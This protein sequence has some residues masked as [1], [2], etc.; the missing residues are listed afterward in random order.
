[1]STGDVLK[2]LFADE[3]VNIGCDTTE[4]LPIIKFSTDSYPRS[5]FNCHCYQN[6]VKRAT[7]SERRKPLKNLF[8]KR[9][10]ST[11]LTLLLCFALTSFLGCQKIT[12]RYPWVS[13]NDKPQCR[14]STFV[15]QQYFGHPPG[16]FPYTVYYNGQGNPDSISANN[17]NAFYYR[18]DANHRL[19]EYSYISSVFVEDV[20]I[21][22]T[23]H[24]WYGYIGNRVVKDSSSLTIEYLNDNPNV[25]EYETVTYP[26]YDQ[27][28]RIIRDSGSRQMTMNGNT[29][30]V[31]LPVDDL[32]SYDSRGDLIAYFES[33]SD[34]PPGDRITYD[35]KKSYLGT[36]NVWMFVTRNYSR[37]NETG[38]TGYNAQ[39][40]PTGFA[41]TDKRG[42][43]QSLTKVEGGGAKGGQ[44]LAITYVCE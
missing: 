43:Q 22:Q 37:H 38:A 7:L 32:Y 24:H 11:G 15:S 5:C 8:M 36:N 13:G 10:S 14:I 6:I 41:P 16:S 35:D 12:D 25:Q 29:N 3:A 18:Y 30:P 33:S 31:P 21:N 2:I 28:N 23:G 39:G 4:I 19:S 20:G 42:G 26:T 40:L 34:G 17:G 44:P 9:E 27:A 1:M